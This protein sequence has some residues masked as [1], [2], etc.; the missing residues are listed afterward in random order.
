M[1]I[2]KYHSMLHDISKLYHEAGQ[3]AKA[4]QFRKLKDH[5]IINRCQK[6]NETI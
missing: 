2:I 5:T 6:I 4:D 1:F 3:I